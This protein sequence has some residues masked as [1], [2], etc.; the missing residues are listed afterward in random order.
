V[1]PRTN[2]A[3]DVAG[4]VYMQNIPLAGSFVVVFCNFLRRNSFRMATTSVDK[5]MGF[6]SILQH[7]VAIVG[8]DFSF[9][10]SGH[11]LRS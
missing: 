11:S 3:K 4:V 9:V 8:A 7:A 5:G 10:L 2:A 6:I 1:L